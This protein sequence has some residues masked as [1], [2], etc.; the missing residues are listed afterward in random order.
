MTEYTIK[1]RFDELLK[2]LISIKM[3]V[4]LVAIG[5]FI[6]GGLSESGF[7]TLTITIFG[8]REVSKYTYNRFNRKD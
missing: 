4:F 1:S 2:K 6:W 7:I 8:L 3:L 5:L